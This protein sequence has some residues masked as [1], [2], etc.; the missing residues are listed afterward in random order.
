MNNIFCVQC[1]K[2]IEANLVTGEVIY[3]HRPD[4]YN[5]K[6][7]QCPFC[8]NYVGT[9]KG[10]TRPLGCIPTLELK[11]ARIKVHNKLDYLWKSGKY[12]RYKIYKALSEYFGYRYHNGTTKS[13]EEC[14]KAIGF[15]E[16]N[17]EVLND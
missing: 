9:H 14:N 6:F 1:N 3:P 12:K 4:L 5:L 11:Q 8:K 17:F 7:Y 10:T 13:I 15:L 2:Y 16:Q